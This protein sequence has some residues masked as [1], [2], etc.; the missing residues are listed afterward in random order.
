MIQFVGKGVYG[1][2][3]IGN[4]SIFKKQDTVVKRVHTQDT[5]RKSVV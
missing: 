4:V 1:A 3:A 5:D 2:I